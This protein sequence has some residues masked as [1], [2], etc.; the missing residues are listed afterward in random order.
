MNRELFHLFTLSL[1][2]IL[3]VN[4]S[5]AAQG[6]IIWSGPT[7][8]FTNTTVADVDQLVSDVWLTRSSSQ[9]IFNAAPGLENS[10]QTSVSP[11]GTQWALGQLANY[12][13]LT[14]SDWATCYG[15]QHNLANK[16][17]G[18]DAVVHLVNSDI[19]LAVKFTSWGGNGGGFSYVRSTPTGTPEPTT[20]SI[21]LTGLLLAGV[22]QRKNFAGNR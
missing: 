21:A 9:G 4:F 3:L 14:Y 7:I 15:G 22:W 2:S 19:Y 17:V 10:Y 11:A 5:A 12:A 1:T 18:S 20:T 6:T 13:A 8:A 16:I